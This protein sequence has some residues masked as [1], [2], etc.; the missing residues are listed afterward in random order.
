MAK[1]K[2]YLFVDSAFASVHIFFQGP[3]TD[4]IAPLYDGYKVLH[5][6]TNRLLLIRKKSVHVRNE[7][8]IEPDHISYR[9]SRSKSL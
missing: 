4:V 1:M 6:S 7:L 2:T 5:R 3:E 9:L 8:T